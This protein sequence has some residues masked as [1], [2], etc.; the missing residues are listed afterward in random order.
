MSVYALAYMVDL[1]MLASDWFMGLGDSYGVDPI[2]FGSIYV[3][4]IPFFWGSVAWIVRNA[5]KGTSVTLPALSAS[6]FMVMAYAYLFWAGENLPIWLY[7]LV[8]A[9][10]VYGGIATVRKVR[11]TTRASKRSNAISSSLPDATRSQK[12]ARHESASTPSVS[13]PRRKTPAYRPAQVTS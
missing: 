13:A 1:W 6:F 7:L 11:S 8:G 2:I 5:R 4:T 3:A 9:C 10:I 12:E